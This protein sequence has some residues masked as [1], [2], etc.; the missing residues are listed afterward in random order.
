MYYS[1]GH[2]VLLHWSLLFQV[3]LGTSGEVVVVAEVA[4]LSHFRK[5]A[6]LTRNIGL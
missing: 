4:V 1:V 6:G 5:R 3:N 2:V